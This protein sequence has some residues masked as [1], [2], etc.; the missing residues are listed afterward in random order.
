MADTAAAALAGI[1]PDSGGLPLAHGFVGRHVVTNKVAVS[2]L[3]HGRQ[4]RYL[5]AIDEPA[6]A[7]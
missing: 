3:Q 6:T 4:R 1:V 7:A 2:P 5:Y